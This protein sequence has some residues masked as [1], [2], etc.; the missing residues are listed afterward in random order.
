ML[1]LLSRIEHGVEQRGERPQPEVSTHT[2]TTY[3]Q[4]LTASTSNLWCPQGAWGGNDEQQEEDLST[5]EVRGHATKLIDVT[6]AATGHAPSS[7]GQCT[8]R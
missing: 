5:G 7:P 8:G 4:I 1:R 6:A 3:R 2:L